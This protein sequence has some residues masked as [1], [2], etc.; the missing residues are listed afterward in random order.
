LFGWIAG[1]ATAATCAG[2]LL[3]D[4]NRPANSW[5]GFFEGESQSGLV[6]FAGFIWLVAPAVAVLAGLSWIMMLRSLPERAI[7]LGMAALV[8]AVVMA[9][10]AEVMYANVRYAFVGQYAW[11][12]LGGCGLAAC[13]EAMQSRSL[14]LATIPAAIVLVGSSVQVAQF[15]TVGAG[16]ETRWP[17]A[18]AYLETHR[19][20]GEPILSQ[21]YVTWV[22]R[23]Y[24]GA[25]D[26]IGVRTT[27]ELKRAIEESKGRVWIVDRAGA[28]GGLQF[29]WLEHNADLRAQFGNRVWQPHSVV[30]VFSYPP[31]DQT[32]GRA[33]G[34]EGVKPEGLTPSQ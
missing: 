33:H 30:R 2:V 8:P 26:S 27:E 16:H 22:M 4:M 9:V 12:L 18:V 6:L 19:R 5:G 34:E 21:P 25:N 24:R 3:Y 15:H 31:G 17:D 13:Y 11:L 1:I 7:Y 23:Y 29:P 10:L 20:E 28:M 32:G 14:V